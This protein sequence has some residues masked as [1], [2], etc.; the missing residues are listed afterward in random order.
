MKRI[1][2][3]G[4]LLLVNDSIYAD[5]IDGFQGVEAPKSKVQRIQDKIDKYTKLINDLPAELQKKIDNF[6]RLKGLGNKIQKVLVIYIVATEEC[7]KQSH[8]AIGVEACGDLSELDLGS[9]IKS[10]KEKVIEMIAEAER[11]LKIVQDKQKDITT[12]EKILK[13][14]KSTKDMMMNY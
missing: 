9:E 10:K 3:I 11:E 12:I 14:L 2:L 5:Q 1:L 13:T 8:S 7:V 6:Q 4:C